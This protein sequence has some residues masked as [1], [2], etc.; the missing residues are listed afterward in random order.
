MSVRR[1]WQDRADGH[2]IEAEM[3]QSRNGG[4]V[5]VE[6]RGE[7]DRRLEV[8][9]ADLDRKAVANI[10]RRQQRPGKLPLQRELPQTD[11]PF[12]DPARTATAAAVVRR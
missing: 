4:A 7:T 12:P 6:A 1:L 5:L 10:A 11:G 9:V 3:L 2:I 8:P